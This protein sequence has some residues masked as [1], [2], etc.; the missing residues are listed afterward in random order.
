MS[1]F[2]NIK[3]YWKY[4]LLLLFTSALFLLVYTAKKNN[5]TATFS[6][7]IID[8]NSVSTQLRFSCYRNAIDEYFKSDL[9]ALLT[10]IKN[11]KELNFS[12]SQGSKKDIDYAIFG[13][14]CHSFYHAVGDFITTSTPNEDIK[15]AVNYCPTS[16]TSGCIMGLYKRKALEGKFDSNLLTNLF[17]YCPST[18]MHQCTH[19]IG[20]LLHDKYTISILNTLDEI[21]LK[22]YNLAPAANYSYVTYEKGDLNAPFTE[23][24]KILPESE[25]PYCFTGIG[26]NLFLFAEFNPRG[27]ASIVDE[28]QKA[29]VKNRS[30]CLGFAIYRIGINGAATK[31]LSKKYDEGNT[32][33]QKAITV[34]KRPDLA[35][36][37]YLGIGGGIGL[38]I[39]SEYVSFNVTDEN[40][41][42]IRK[43]VL[44]WVD[45]CK[46]TKS[47]FVDQ[48]YKGLLGT[49]LKKIYKTLNLE[50]EVI[51]RILPTVESDFE[52]VG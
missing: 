39:E 8:C 21:T 1:M 13:T 3:K 12:Q 31:F 29:D 46:Y 6:Q 19:E 22:E 41:G 33:C 36:H 28:C 27:T 25:W 43:Q 37:C 26:H 16:C 17:K 5:R 32:T 40:V 30:D 44:D 2:S 4:L 50:H 20:H 52:V 10:S 7:T 51:E 11:H 23:C 45:L 38:F 42:T 48:C 35:Y 47:D 15:T 34:A 9:K 24:R 18:S 14:N 49:P